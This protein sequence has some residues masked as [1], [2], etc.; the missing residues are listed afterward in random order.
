MHRNIRL[1]E[2]QPSAVIK[3]EP[4]LESYTRNC[5]P[6]LF[7]NTGWTIRLSEH[8][9]ILPYGLDEPSDAVG[10][11]MLLGDSVLE[12][13]F[14][15]E[16]SRIESILFEKKPSVRYL[17]HGRSSSTSVDILNTIVN[18]IV[19]LQP[20]K[21][22]LLSGVFDVGVSAYGLYS[23]VA[24][25]CTINGAS[26]PNFKFDIY[27]TRKNFLL[28]K[29]RLLKS[30]GITV[31]LGTFGHRH[32]PLDPYFNKFGSGPSDKANNPYCLINQVARD[33][34][35]EADEFI[36]FEHLMYSEFNCFYDQ[37]HLTAAGAKI[38]ADKLSEC[39]F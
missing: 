37:W 34:R 23:N 17:N 8:G 33:C 26:F 18:K 3:F 31:Y 24:K 32:N 5:I 14:M 11:S 4:Q 25:S 22:F 30:F 1:Y 19:P 7:Q 6:E 2:Y 10:S 15:H 38:I 12:C 35:M 20:R 9:F 39:G 21:V 29:I 28:T 27:E 13:L 36:D 16:R